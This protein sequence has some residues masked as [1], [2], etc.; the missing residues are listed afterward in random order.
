MSLATDVCEKVRECLAGDYEIEDTD[1]IPS[2][3]DVPFGN[4]AK[5]AELCV[6]YIDLRRSTDLLFVHRKQTAGKIHK[7][8]LHAAASTV[9]H[10]GGYI[11]S[12]KG[13]SLMAMWPSGDR[14]LVDRCVRAAMVIKWFLD[15]KLESEFSQYSR[16]DFGIGVDLGEVL[17]A[18][19]GIPRDTNNNDLIF[20]GKCINRAVAIGEQAHGPNHVQISK[21]TYENLDE[22]LVY[23]TEKDWLVGEYKHNMWKNRSL[24][25]HGEDVSLKVTN[26]YVEI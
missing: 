3:E 20:M 10:Y 9:L 15:V 24:G 2:V 18:R 1:E 19:A 4:V 21:Y 16:V 14:S 22:D 11:R 7:A 23:V 25:W 12:F 13:D 17:I 26:Y 8:F 5:R 6:L